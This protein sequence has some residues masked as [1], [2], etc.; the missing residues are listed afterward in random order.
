MI[1]PEA[2]R[3]DN[4]YSYCQATLRDHDKDRYLADLFI[5]ADIR[6][7]AHALH[8]FSYEIARVRDVVSEP[9]SGELR[10][11]WWRDAIEGA[12]LEDQA[13][14]RQPAGDAQA[15]P[16]AAAL[17]DSVARHHL[18]REAFI[19]LI[20]ARGFDLYDDPMPD[21]ATLSD[22]CRDTSSILFHLVGRMLERQPTAVRQTPPLAKTDRPLGRA[23]NSAGLAYAFCGLIGA[24]ARHAARGQLYLPGDILMRHG[25]S[26]E[27]AIGGKATPSLMAALSEW[28]AEARSHLAS[29]RLAIAI[30]PEG[31]KPA[32]R[33][34]ALVEPYLA[35][36]EKRGYD[37]FNPPP[38]FA[39]WRRQWA[40]W[41][42]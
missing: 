31:V 18:P 9:M 37:P 15:N 24:F 41:H 19:A 38:E 8:A 30:L 11:Q 33:P 40:L 5:P 42:G 14:G 12:A 16:I 6:H 7:H 4:A 2:D 20:E 26:R 28:R 17:L 3:L 22:Y 36:T 27:E 1:D 32:F 21:L 25:T 34:L 10:H 13:R 23:A 29:A 39:Q 35:R